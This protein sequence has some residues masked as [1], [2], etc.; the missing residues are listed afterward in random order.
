MEWRPSGSKIC[1][2]RNVF[3]I[4]FSASASKPTICACVNITTVTLKE[5]QNLPVSIPQLLCACVNRPLVIPHHLNSQK[6]CHI[7]L[8]WVT[9]KMSIMI[10]SGKYYHAIVSPYCHIN[11]H[12][13]DNNG[14]TYLPGSPNIL[15]SITLL[16][17]CPPNFTLCCWRNLGPILLIIFHTILYQPDLKDWEI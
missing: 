14:D 13:R 1:P 17:E 7:S 12:S 8:T 5:C 16:K 2:T 10:Y 11:F 3:N 4:Q 6:T 9:D 15:H